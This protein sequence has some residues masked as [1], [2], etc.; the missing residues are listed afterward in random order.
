MLINNQPNKSSELNLHLSL[1]S[2]SLTQ[3]QTVK[4]LGVFID[5]NLKCSTYI[6]HL[7]QQLSRCF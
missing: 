5:D 4:Y 3:Q 7:L 1:N 2:F 6:H